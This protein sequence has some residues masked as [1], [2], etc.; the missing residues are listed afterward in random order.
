MKQIITAIAL[1]FIISSC[2]KKAGTVTDTT[3]IDSLITNYKKSAAQEINEKDIIFWK[4]KL[5]K[6]PVGFLESQQYAGNLVARFHLYGDIKDLKAADS[7]LHWLNDQYKEADAGPLRTLAGY[8]ILQHRFHEAYEYV[9]KALALGSER[10]A[11]ELLNFDAVFELGQDQLAKTILARLKQDNEYGYFFRLSKYKHLEGALDSSIAAM[12]KATELAGNSVGLRQTAIS[13][14]GDLYMHAADPENANKLYMQSILLDASDLHSLMGIGWIALVHDGKDTLAEKIFKFI[15]TKTK[16]PEVLLKL[17]QVAEQRGDSIAEKKYADEFVGI[18]TDSIY[19]NMYNKYLVDLY[20][21]FLHQ[22]AKAL[23]IAERELTNRVT[24]QTYSWYVWSLYNNN[25]QEKALSIYD[26]F[27][28]GKPLEGLELYYM[29][30][31][32]KGIGKGY[33]AEQYFKVAYKNRYDLSP[34]KQKDLDEMMK[35]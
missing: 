22:P 35:H 26:K 30:K 8:A 5:D 7:I 15:Q 34:A 12:K 11:S 16:S 9:Q 20:N 13:N 4:N 23:A 31:M 21:G 27:V 24:P 3:F 14:T 33:N 2:N 17:A 32:M 29:G 28:S 6:A 18:V 19:G 10:Y 1:V 25:Q